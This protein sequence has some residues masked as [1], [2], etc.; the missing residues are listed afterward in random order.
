M[1]RKEWPHEPDRV[2]DDEWQAPAAV[3]V[4]LLAYFPFRR[5]QSASHLSGSQ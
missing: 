4:C 5:L 2:S 1:P 3:V